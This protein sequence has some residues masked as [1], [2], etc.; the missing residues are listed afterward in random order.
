MSSNKV[1]ESEYQQLINQG[2]LHVEEK[3]WLEQFKGHAHSMVLDWALQVAGEALGAN[4]NRHIR[5]F[6]QIANHIRKEQVQIEDAINMPMPFQYFHIM[7]LML[8]INFTLWAYGMGMY[9]SYIASVI[10]VFSLLIFLGMKELSAALSDPFGDDVVDFPLNDWIMAYWKDCHHFLEA[11]VLDVVNRPENFEGA[12]ELWTP[13][14]ANLIDVDCDDSSSEGEDSIYSKEDEQTPFM[15]QQQVE[16]S[17]G[18]SNGA[19]SAPKAKPRMYSLRRGRNGS[20][21]GPE[22]GQEAP[23]SESD[24]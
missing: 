4:R 24:E 22:A 8:T 9:W 14:V 11:D 16:A 13:E 21:Q 18:P 17:L 5:A 3:V 12:A 23:D 7:N 10:F 15:A 6:S 1:S 19:R 2:L 20:R